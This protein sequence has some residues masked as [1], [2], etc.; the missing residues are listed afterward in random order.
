MLCFWLEVD[1]AYQLYN[2]ICLAQQWSDPKFDTKMRLLSVS[3]SLRFEP[4]YR[5]QCTRVAS[6][7][8]NMPA[9][10]AAAVSF[11][12]TAIYSSQTAVPR[13]LSGAGRTL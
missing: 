2:V 4:M 5:Q 6:L 13:L 10:A 3:G 7:D 12:A 8:Q 11:R 1:E 9:G